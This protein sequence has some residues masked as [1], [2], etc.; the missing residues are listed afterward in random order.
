MTRIIDSSGGK[1]YPFAMKKSLTTTIVL[2]ILPLFLQTCSDALSNDYAGE[3]TLEVKGENLEIHNGSSHPIYYFAVETGTAS[4]IKWTPI[5]TNENRIKAKY[6]RLISLDNI[7]GYKP[8]STILFYYWSEK[9]PG[10][11]NISLKKIDTP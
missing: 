7:S 9:E 10:S 8:G 2:I 6:T 5:S 4:V 1:T 3:V 11:E